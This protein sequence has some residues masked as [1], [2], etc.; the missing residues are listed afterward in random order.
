MPKR[1]FIRKSHSELVQEQNRMLQALIAAQESKEDKDKSV[2]Y[3]VMYDDAPSKPE[4]LSTPEPEPESFSF[5]DE[6]AP[7]VPM[8]TTVTGKAKLPSV[9]TDKVMFDEEGVEKLKKRKAKAGKL[10]NQGE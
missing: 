3:K 4:V 7:F 6:D 9:N 10:D 8:M 5:D 1:Y 2:V